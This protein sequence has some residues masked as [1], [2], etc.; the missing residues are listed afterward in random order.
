MAIED[1]FGHNYDLIIAFMFAENLKSEYLIR[2]YKSNN[3]DIYIC[4]HYNLLYK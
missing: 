2:E 1:A 3:L 4:I